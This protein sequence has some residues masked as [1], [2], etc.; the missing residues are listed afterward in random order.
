MRIRDGAIVELRLSHSH[1]ERSFGENV[2]RLTTIGDDR[3]RNWMTI[4]VAA[5]GKDRGVPTQVL[6]E[7]DIP[8]DEVGKFIAGDSSRGQV[9]W[10]LDDRLKR[11]RTKKREAK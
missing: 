7:V 2:T 8:L 4:Q 10:S 11:A 1:G 9:T 5:A 6:F 3:H